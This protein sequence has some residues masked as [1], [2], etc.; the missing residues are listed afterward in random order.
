[1]LDYVK[2]DTKPDFRF[3]IERENEAVPLAAAVSVTFKLY[4]PSGAVVARTC[5]VVG[6]GSTGAVVGTWTPGDLNES[7]EMYGD[8][9]IDW[10]GGNVEHGLAP[11]RVRVREEGQP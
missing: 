8:V 4:K 3:E 7:G 10:G 9:S 1:M 6:D 11:V 2:N 5:A